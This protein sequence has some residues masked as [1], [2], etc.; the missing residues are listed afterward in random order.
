MSRST[1]CRRLFARALPCAMAAAVLVLTSWP[2][3][4]VDGTWNQNASGN[5]LDTTKWLDGIVA[6]GVGST[7]TIAANNSATQTITLTSPVTLGT[8]TGGDTGGADKSMWTITGSTLTLD[9]H[10]TGIARINTSNLTNTTGNLTINSAVTVV[11]QLQVDTANGKTFIQGGIFT[12]TDSNAANRIFTIASGQIQ[13]G[14]VV[15]NPLLNLNGGGMS[16]IYQPRDLRRACG[17]RL[18]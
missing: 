17:G 9:N 18:Y 11:G 8:I 14:A 16:H 15:G 1:V 12:F 13:P 3:L 2:A 4:A 6:G 10:S 7:M 5:W